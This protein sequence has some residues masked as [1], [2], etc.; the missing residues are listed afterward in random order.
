M[1]QIEPIPALQDNYI[2]L[3]HRGDEAIVIDPGESTPVLELLQARGL[4]LQAILIT[5]HHQDHTGGVTAL[6]N[7]T[8]ARVFAP[9]SCT[10]NSIDQPLEGGERLQLLDC[11]FQVWAT[12]AHTLDHLIYY[13]ADGAAQP[14]LFSGDTLFSAGCGRLFEGDASQL[15]SAMEL[16]ASLP[17]GTQLCCAHEYTLSNLAFAQAV[18]PGNKN[19]TSHLERCQQL[20][21][22][23][24]PT[25]PSSLADE[26]QINPFLRYRAQ[27]VV[28][29]AQQ[30]AG[31][32]LT[33]DKA[34]LA[35]LRSWKDQ[36]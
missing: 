35:E 3:L 15:F 25:L 11:S 27:A 1:L 23:G 21:Q 28:K 9:A 22:Q 12:P 10:L 2:W 18:E 32:S 16:I 36:F 14:Y 7:A 29:A 17:P 13:C 19:I 5:H 8:G 26:L 6:K 34:V 24:L 30:H 4:N 33:E 31:R 20:R